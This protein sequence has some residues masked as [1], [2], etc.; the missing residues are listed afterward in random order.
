VI[1][2]PYGDQHVMHGR[3]RFSEVTSI[4]TLM[5]PP[6]WESL[7]VIHHGG[8]GART[9]VVCGYLTSDHPLFDPGLA[10]LPDVFVVRPQGA[11]LAWMRASI[12]YAMD[13]APSATTRPR[14]AE[15]LVIEVLRTHLSS[16]SSAA[17]ADSRWLTALRD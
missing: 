11:A 10:A 1:V 14:L 17:S 12:A 3:T 6:P 8:G 2:L 5:D 15:L 4:L 16:L 7:P 13:G 9:D